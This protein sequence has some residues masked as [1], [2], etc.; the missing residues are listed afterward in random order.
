[1]VYGING[2]HRV[3]GRSGGLVDLFGVLMCAL[4]GWMYW[5][6]GS[7]PSMGET[8]PPVL[9]S[10]YFIPHVTVVIMG[11]GAGLCA[12]IM[13]LLFLWQARGRTDVQLETDRGLASID[14][15]CAARCSAFRC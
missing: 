8:V 10:P 2:M 7:K 14:M 9:K 15:F 13:G 6:A 4:V 12:A 3:K 11:Y 1:V 5:Y